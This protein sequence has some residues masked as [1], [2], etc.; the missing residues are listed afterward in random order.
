MTGF[1]R[2]EATGADVS[3][4]VEIR[5]VNN[6][7]L[8]V[9]VRAPREYM[10]LESVVTRQVKS[11]CRRGRVE[12]HVKR[13]TVNRRAKVLPDTLLFEAYVDTVRELWASKADVLDDREALLFALRQPG[14]LEVSHEETDVLAESEVLETALEVAIDAL[15]EMRQTEGHALYQDMQRHLLALLTEVDA[16]EAQVSGLRDRLTERMERRVN[17][18]L[19][20][21][22]EP[23]RLLQEVAIL[24]ERADISEEITRLKSHLLQFRDAMERDEAIGRRL[25]FL[26]QE[27]NREINTIGSKASEHPV[28]HRVV[29]MKAILER[30]REQAANV[31]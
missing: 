19:G 26:L 2:G 29:E 20:E 24:A 17:R 13:S 28:S 8:D 5:S 10:A 21:R 16:V 1:G 15:R 3:V 31:E 14:V 23:W 12:V 9:Q 30:M 22:H 4:V 27:M 6:R 7:F 25:D 11:A 18:L